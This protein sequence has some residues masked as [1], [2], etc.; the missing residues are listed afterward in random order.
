AR[1]EAGIVTQAR[2]PRGGF[3]RLNNRDYPPRETFDSPSLSILRLNVNLH[4]PRGCPKR[5]QTPSG[6]ESRARESSFKGRGL[7]PFWTPSGRVNNLG[8]P[9]CK[10]AVGVRGWCSRPAC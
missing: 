5:G 6:H 3:D 1:P 9:V 7:T 10:L 8:E 2:E 4:E